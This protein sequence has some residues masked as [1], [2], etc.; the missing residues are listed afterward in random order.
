MNLVSLLSLE[1][2]EGIISNKKLL[3]IVNTEIENCKKLKP[4]ILAHLD[5][6]EEFYW[7]KGIS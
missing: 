3:E 4:E 1:G 7:N 6:I 2:L 5:D